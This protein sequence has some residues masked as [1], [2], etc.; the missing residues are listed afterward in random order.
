MTTTTK[1]KPSV[2]MLWWSRL[3]AL[4]CAINVVLLALW[5]R[6]HCR[7]D[8]SEALATDYAEAYE[9]MREIADVP[10][11]NDVATIIAPSDPSAEL[12]TCNSKA[13]K[14]ARANT[15][16]QLSEV[17]AADLVE[18]SFDKQHAVGFATWSRNEQ[19]TNS[20]CL[21]YSPFT[22]EQIPIRRHF[23][24]RLPLLGEDFAVR[25]EFSEITWDEYHS[26]RNPESADAE[27]MLAERQGGEL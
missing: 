12:I 22:A 18:D 5:Y 6:E 25:F 27:P 14:A 19:V 2:S 13:R 16:L 4:S 23:L 21:M 20:V 8:D 15:R 26:A 10:N 24:K 11:I 1:C 3:V 9:S 7:A 17:T